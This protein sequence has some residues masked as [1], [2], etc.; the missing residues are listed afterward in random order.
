MAN[1]NGR[2]PAYKAVL[3]KNETSESTVF[4]FVYSS[5]DA[6]CLSHLKKES[7]EPGKQYFYRDEDVFKYKIKTQKKGTKKAKKNVI[8]T[9]KK[10]EEDTLI[11]VKDGASD[12]ALAHEEA[13][14]KY[15]DERQIAI[16]RK[17]M[18]EET[19]GEYG[20]DFYGILKLNMKEVRKNS[21]E[22]Q[23]KIIKKAYHRQMLIFHPDRNPDL[24]DD[25]MCQEIVMAYSILGDRKKRALYHDVTDYSG[26]RLSKSHWKAIFKPEA[27]GSGEKWKRIGLLVFS[28]ALVGGGFTITIFTAGLGVGA[29]FGGSIAAGALIGGATQGAFR[30][31]SYDSIENGVTVKK[32][33]KSFAVGAGIG[34]LGGGACAGITAGV[35]GVE[36]TVASIVEA[37][38]GELVG[39]GAAVGATNGA[40]SSISNDIDSVIVDGGSKCSEEVVKN[41]AKGAA[42]GSGIGMVCS[43]VA[44]LEAKGKLAGKAKAGL[45]AIKSNMFEGSDRADRVVT[46]LSLGCSMNCEKRYS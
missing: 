34:A 15:P 44:K 16:R 35:M 45:K 22:E 32:Y 33:A 42:I 24:G 14:S 7:I 23:D 29:F 17:N 38:A 1:S 2:D 18:K 11:L 21:L 5:F 3:V 19:S 28:A 43:G 30:V 25:E 41:I 13:L 26:G 4:L 31:I 10:W 40:M 37:S 8:L 39:N 27:H 46:P 9:L 20:R 12:E 36:A 6:I